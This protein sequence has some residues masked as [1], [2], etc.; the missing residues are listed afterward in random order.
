[1]QCFQFAVQLNLMVKINIFHFNFSWI[2]YISVHGGW[3][4]WDSWSSCSVTCG[5]GQKN[6]S[7]SCNNP[8]P[9][10]GGNPCT[11]DASEIVDCVHDPC[12]SMSFMVLGLHCL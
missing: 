5:T 11:G 1:M 3:S 8:E 12:I 2:L 4:I 10:H 6:R 9:K 7:R